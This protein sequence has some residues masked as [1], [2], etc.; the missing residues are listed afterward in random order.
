[1]VFLILVIWYGFEAALNAR[2]QYGAILKLSMIWVK[3]NIPLGSLF[4]LIHMVYFTV[5]LVREKKISESISSAEESKEGST[6]ELRTDFHGR[7]LRIRP[8]DR[9]S[10]SLRS[11][12]RTSGISHRR[13]GHPAHSRSPTKLYA[14]STTTCFSPCPSSSSRATS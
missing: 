2:R 3:M 10:H 1:M 5:G 6:Y 11:G 12:A 7:N 8:R 14:G 9:H 13:Q 4:M